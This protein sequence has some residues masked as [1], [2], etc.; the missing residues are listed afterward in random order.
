MSNREINSLYTA[1]AKD[2]GLKKYSKEDDIS[3]HSRLLYS[4]TALW[5]LTLFNDKNAKE[6]I[7]ISKAHVTIVAKE[8]LYSFLKIDPT[9]DIYFSDPDKFISVIEDTYIEMGFINSDPYTFKPIKNYLGIA[10]SSKSSISIEQYNGK[11]TQM[12]GLAL[13][14]EHQNEDL[15]LNKYF[16][17]EITAEET[18]SRLIKMKEFKTIN[19][20]IGQIELYDF[21]KKTWLPYSVKQAAKFSYSI[22]CIDKLNYKIL[23]SIDNNIQFADLP[24]IYQKNDNSKFLDHEIWRL[25]LG[26]ASYIGMPFK[27]KFKD[28]E[29]FY[30]IS[31]KGYIIPVFEK[32]LLLCSA[33]PEEF[34]CRTQKYYVNHYIVPKEYIGFVEQIF[35]HLSIEI[36]SE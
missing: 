4:A 11:E 25:I 20:N 2:I 13:I 3:Y 24:Y 19:I 30:L 8:I 33:W 31:M 16:L 21:G 32:R 5:I 23:K 12:V 14:R 17:S 35:K 15:E 7:C 28:R 29:D 36:E 10:L 26:C 34:A 22:A 27:T 9:Q 18:F 1:I 6:D